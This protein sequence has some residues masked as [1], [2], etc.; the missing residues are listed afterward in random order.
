M[1]VHAAAASRL[2]LEVFSEETVANAARSALQELGGEATLGFVFASVDYRPHL[3]DLLE[4]LTLHGHVPHLLGCCGSGLI[5]TG[6]EIEKAIGFS[7]LLLH[8][9][10]TKLHF[11]EISTDDAASLDTPEEWHAFTGA[12]PDE[13]ESW[14]ALID[15]FGF[16]IEPWLEGWNRAY[17]GIPMIGGLS[18]NPHTDAEAEE[19]FVTH[20]REI[21]P[22]SSAML[23]GFKGGIQVRSVLAQ[24]CRPIGEPLTITGTNGNLLLRLGGKKAYSALAEAFEGLSD[25]EKASAQG[26]L[27]AGLASSEYIDEFALGDFLIRSILGADASSGS[28][29]LGAQLRVGQSLQWQLRDAASAMRDLDTRL[30]REKKNGP[31]P[32][33]SLVFSCHGRGEELFG[34]GGYDADALKKTFGPLPSAGLFCNGEI[35]PIREQNYIHGYTAS[36]ALFTRA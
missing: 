2:V 35:S 24:G 12:A 4:L 1:S 23:I 13:V 29:A 20:N 34:K 25:E 33:A 6:M 11:C 22:P 18:S 28:V 5:G 30:A 10:E 3:D 36:I 7:L 8:L 21:L 32:F 19:V 9:P 27:F 16:P 14:I 15:P 17:P 26:N 31:P